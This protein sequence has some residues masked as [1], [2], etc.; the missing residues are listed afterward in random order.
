MV[1]LILNGDREA[2]TVALISRL[3][4]V[5]VS[6]IM[7]IA[8]CLVDFWAGVSAAKAEGTKLNSHGFRKTIVKIGD[9]FK[10]ALVGMMIDI[11]GGFF[12]WYDLPYATILFSVASII[13]EGKS[14]FENVKRKRTGVEKVGELAKAI[15]ECDNLEE[16]L[17]L[18]TKLSDLKAVLMKMGKWKAQEDKPNESDLYIG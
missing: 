10:V 1:D 12:S 11:V 16:A 17:R 5:F 9:Y 4:I 6:W 13:I 8:V 14:V 3:G 18:V 7:I 15:M 2:L